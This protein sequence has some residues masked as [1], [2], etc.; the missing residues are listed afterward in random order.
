MII[1][2][3]RYW[4]PFKAQLIDDIFQSEVIKLLLIFPFTLKSILPVALALDRIEVP[5]DVGLVKR[6]D[7]HHHEIP[8]QH[9]AAEPLVHLP[10]VW[11]RGA[12][13]EHHGGEE[14]QGG[15]EDAL[16]KHLDTGPGGDHTGL[17]EP[18]ETW[19]QMRRYMT[20]GCMSKLHAQVQNR[21]K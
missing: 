15:V 16:V 18:G 17:Q 1:S 7:T 19:Q 9:D 20:V 4:K 21:C 8:E 5:E 3:I 10:V 6:G 2:K 11:V 12:D 13:E 14:R